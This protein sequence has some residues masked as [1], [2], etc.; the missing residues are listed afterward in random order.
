MGGRG[1]GC[2]FAIHKENQF[3]VQPAQF[4]QP[5]RKG[6]GVVA[7]NRGG[8][9]PAVKRAGWMN[10]ERGGDGMVGID[11]GGNGIPVYCQGQT[12]PDL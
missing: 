10:R 7:W 1:F 9:A 12:L 3:A 6:L 5:G 11:S 2:I 8:G 4:A